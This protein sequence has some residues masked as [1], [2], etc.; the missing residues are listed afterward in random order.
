MG[1][2]ATTY[3]MIAFV[4]ATVAAVDNCFEGNHLDFIYRVPDQS[5]NYTSSKEYWMRKETI[6]DFS[7]TSNNMI[8]WYS[9]SIKLYYQLYWDAADDEG[10]RANPT[11]ELQP[12]IKG[13]PWEMGIVDETGFNPGTL[14]NVKYMIDNDNIHH[15]LRIQIFKMADADDIEPEE[16]AALKPVMFTATIALI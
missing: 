15:D 1:L 4:L 5:G 9:S 14:C 6:C 8:T 12:Y 16:L 2:K 13:K 3:L 7:L 11:E 10:C